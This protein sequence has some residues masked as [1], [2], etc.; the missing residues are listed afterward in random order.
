LGLSKTLSK[1][2]TRVWYCPIA[3]GGGCQKSGLWS[4]WHLQSL[5]E[6]TRK[7]LCIAQLQ[8][9]EAV[10]SQGFGRAGIFRPGM[11][12][13][14]DKARAIEKVSVSLCHVILELM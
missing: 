2:K 1:Y 8:A 3:G 14:G 10:K 13:R 12:D 7:K 4:C 9:E 6:Q 11:L 5:S